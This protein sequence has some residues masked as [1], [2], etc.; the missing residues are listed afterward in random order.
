MLQIRNT[1]GFTI[2]EMVI[3]MTIFALMSV[4]ITTIYIQTTYISEKLRHTRYLSEAAREITE[5]IADDVRTLGI[6]GTTLPDGTTY[7]YWNDGDS[8]SQSGSEVLS[9]GDGSRKYVFA[10]KI[11]S[12][13]TF[14]L[15]H[16]DA[17]D[18]IDPKIHCG[19]YILEGTDYAGAFNLMDSFIPEEDKKRIK[20]ENFKFFV[21][22][23]GI[24]TEK[25]V[26]LVFTLA[27]M[28]RIG[29]PPSMVSDTRLHV[30]TTISER[31]FKVNP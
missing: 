15:D 30:Q 11:P 27:L 5:R 17:V 28:P 4:T 22:G 16:C 31:F 29:V 1:S 7:R 24:H 23:D 25:K 12:G 21:S 13:S 8:Y 3:A 10:K 18:K 20:W 6:K 19:L 14:T 9:V 26:T 2:V